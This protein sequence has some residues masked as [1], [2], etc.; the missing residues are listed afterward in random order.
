MVKVRMLICFLML[1]PQGAW[2]PPRESWVLES[3][4]WLKT[5]F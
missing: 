2:V 1:A 3:E 4:L 5:R